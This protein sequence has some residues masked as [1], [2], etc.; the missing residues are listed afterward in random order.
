MIFYTHKLKHW[1]DLQDLIYVKPLSVEV[2]NES[3]IVT[4]QF[5][6]KGNGRKKFEKI[7][8]RLAK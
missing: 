5:Y 6:L 4:V 2:N 3:S 8:E 7:I 1:K